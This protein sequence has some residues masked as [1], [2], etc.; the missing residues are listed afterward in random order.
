MTVQIGERLLLLTG[1]ER[2][3]LRRKRAEQG[4]DPDRVTSATGALSANLRYAAC[5][6]S[7]AADPMPDD[8][9]DFR[10]AELCESAAIITL[11][12]AP[13]SVRAAVLDGARPTGP[14]GYARVAER[15]R[16]LSTAAAVLLVV[17]AWFDVLTTPAGHRLQS[18]VVAVAVELPLASVCLWLS[19]HTQRLAERRIVCCDASGTQARG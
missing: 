8:S 18:I 5:G 11:G 2:D 16:Y 15:S 9:G 3:I 17:A 1:D 4:R 6:F 13:L 10:S 19:Y 7:L 14:S 12:A